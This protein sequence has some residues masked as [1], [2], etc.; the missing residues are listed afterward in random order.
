[1]AI[2]CQ[3][4]ASEQKFT[5]SKQSEFKKLSEFLTKKALMINS[6]Y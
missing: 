4:Y 6:I 2:A 5:A 3:C 1:M